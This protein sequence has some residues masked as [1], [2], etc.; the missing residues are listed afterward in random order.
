MSP[1][2]KRIAVNG[3]PL[4]YADVGHGDTLLFVH[5]AISD[6]R[7]WAPQL[8]GF[9][10]P[11][12]RIALNQRYFGLDPWPDRPSREWREV[13]VADLIAFLETLGASPAHLVGS[14]YGGEIVLAAATRRP[15]LARSVLVNEPTVAS[16]VTDPD[17]LAT[18]QR[19]GADVAP[20]VTAL[21][22]GD[23][24]QA[25]RMFA[26]WTANLARRFDDLTPSFQAIF[27]DNART[28]GAQLA[29]NPLNL[30]AAQ[31]AGLERPVTVTVGSLTRPFFRVIADAVLRTLETS[32]LVVIPDAHHGA[33]F[34]NAPAFNAALVEHLERSRPAGAGAPPG[35]EP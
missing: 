32:R 11:F 20:A 16:I 4:T 25:T 21:K 23:A 26:E 34:E 14:S 5:G 30:S 27:L 19:E 31:L 28:L 6:H 17:D 13:H 24:Q 22:A 18:L 12:R 7:I 35:A 3:T 10:G 29:A 15:D 33:P 1:E 9:E 8:T 2:I